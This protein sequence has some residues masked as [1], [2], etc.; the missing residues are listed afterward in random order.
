MVF[1]VDGNTSI[2]GHCLGPKFQGSLTR[3]SEV[4]ARVR[5]R[6]QRGKEITKLIKKRNGDRVGVGFYFCA[7][8][9]RR[10]RVPV[11]CRLWS[12]CHASLTRQTSALSGGPRGASLGWGG[13]WGNR[14]GRGSDS[15]FPPEGLTLWGRATLEDGGG[16][17]EKQR[18]RQGRDLVGRQEPHRGTHLATGANSHFK[19][20]MPAFLPTRPSGSPRPRASL[21]GWRAEGL[22]PQAQLSS[23]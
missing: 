18:P 17:S 23:Q 20:S 9:E 7:G 19:G 2:T 14:G 4:R 10:R 6:V 3:L 5:F 16:P 22:C 21:V 8:R 12:P 1:I 13:C 15:P 11:R